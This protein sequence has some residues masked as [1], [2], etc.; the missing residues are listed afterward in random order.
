MSNF[1]P[2]AEI[3]R[4]YTDHKAVIL[5][6]RDV[7]EIAKNQD[8]FEGHVNIPWSRFGQYIP[9]L[10]S[11]NGV[12]CPGGDKDCHLLVIC[13]RGRR[14]QLAIDELVKCGYTNTHNCENPTRMREA[15]PD[16]A[17]VSVANTLPPLSSDF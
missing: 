5:D 12:L 6:V 9:L 10:G 2:P 11:H 7:D 15:L 1:Q 14:A 17:R 13:A 8:G 4:L 3:R 16:V